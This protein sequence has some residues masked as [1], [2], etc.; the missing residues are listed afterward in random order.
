MPKEETKKEEAEAAED[1]KTENPD[2]DKKNV[3]TPLTLQEAQEKLNQQVGFEEQKSFVL[4]EINARSFL[5]NRSIEQNFPIFCFVGPP[6]VGKTTFAR[7]L[8]EALGKPFFLLALGGESKPSTLTG[9]TTESNRAE[10]GKIAK[11]LI[12]GEKSDPFIL[13][14]EIDKTS[15]HDTLNPFLD[16]AQ[17]QNIHEHCLEIELDFSKITFAATANDPKKI[18]DYLRSRMIIIEL[19]EYTSEQKKEIAFN[20]LQ[21]LVEENN[22]YQDDQP[23]L[24]ITDEALDILISKTHEKGVRQLKTA[25]ENNI[26]QKDKL[27]NIVD[28]NNQNKLKASKFR[29]L[30]TIQRALNDANFEKDENILE[31]YDYK[32]EIDNATSPEE[33]EAIREE[34]LL[35]IT[36]KSKKYKQIPTE[37]TKIIKNYFNDNKKPTQGNN[38]TLEKLVQELTKMN[39]NKD[40]IRSL[41]EHDV[42]TGENGVEKEGKRVKKSIN[43]QKEIIQKFLAKNISAGLRQELNLTFQKCCELEKIAPKLESLAQECEKKHQACRGEFVREKGGRQFN[44]YEYCLCDSCY[45]EVVEREEKIE[46]D[47]QAKGLNK[48]SVLNEEMVG[49]VAAEIGNVEY[50]EEEFE[51]HH[52]EIKEHL[53]K[54][55]KEERNNLSPSQIEHLEQRKKLKIG[56]KNKPIQ[57]GEWQT[58]YAADCRSLEILTANLS[59]SKLSKPKPTLEKLTELAMLTRKTGDPQGVLI[60][61]AEPLNH[62]TIPV[63]SQ[64]D[65][66]KKYHYYTNG[67][68]KLCRALNI[69]ISLNGVDLT[70]SDLIY[71]EDGSEV[72]K[73][74]IVITK[75]VN[76]DYAGADKDRLWRFYIKDNPF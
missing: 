64:Q 19:K 32:K 55:L 28:N 57:A 71:L 76:I 27:A 37:K 40:S 69:D 65:E 52:K 16:P 60:R 68:G 10:I 22:L 8:A 35:R 50:T 2:E 47:Y 14:D 20:T 49:R 29:T 24:T 44:I 11:Y 48:L 25:L 56:K 62:H 58:G 75:R 26:F 38:K 33:V 9:S 45:K 36:E 13:L 51:K 34:I 5:E 42:N 1:V 73:D 72:S 12:Q 4:G 46:N 7:T 15:L 18:P 23:L 31:N 17:N 6:G 67:P 21:K 63:I 70:T 43:Y 41:E 59:K 74:E 39:G 53:E 61:A 66:R 3:S 54:K 30:N